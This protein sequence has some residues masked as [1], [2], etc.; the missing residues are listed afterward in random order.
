MVKFSKR[1]KWLIGL[2]FA[3]LVLTALMN[4]GFIAI[5]DYACIIE[6]IIPAQNLTFNQVIAERDIRSPFAPLV[7]LGVTKLGWYLGIQDP[8]WQFRFLSLLVGFFSYSAFSWVGIRLFKENNRK[9]EWFLFL[10]GFYF[11][12]PVFFSRILIESL[13][14]PFITLSCWFAQHY[15]ER[16]DRKS[17]GL[18]LLF[19]VLA[20]MFRFQAGICFVGIFFLVALKRN[21]PELLV[22]VL[23]AIMGFL[24]TGALDYLL[25][26]AFHGSLF[27]YVGYNLKYSSG[28][29]VT[30]FYTFLLIFL[31]L[32][33]P[34]S[35]I[36]RY[37]G[38]SWKQEFAGLIAPVLYIS[39]FLFAHSIVPHKEE[40]FVIPILQLFLIL[41]VPFLAFIAA[42]N[43]RSWRL[44]WF[45]GLNLILLPLACF[46]IAQNNVISLVR[47]LHTNPNIKNIV[48]VE[49][50]FV[51]YTK[52][53]LLKPP[54]L[55]KLSVEDVEQLRG[56][57]CD[58]LIAIRRDYEKQLNQFLKFHTKL[59]EFS[60]GPLEELVIK[61]NPK[62]NIRRGTIALYSDPKCV[63]R[64]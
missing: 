20:S 31:G 39:V 25:T 45:V 43:P 47:F 50:T 62:Q 52:A 17:L 57:D 16:T 46:N 55:I 56:L 18:S 14:M 40:R 38:L 44:K 21:F 32:S 64:F 1:S 42:D 49:E 60:P 51:L 53:F 33:L 11:L 4:I 29:G 22:F 41:L 24:I 48:G 10:S 28:F 23:M 3:L 2:G 34:P 27:T 6:K 9:I 13:S 5:D 61:F 54:K 63:S 58:V 26:G 15:W 19:L 37:C 12:S 7:L 8:A 59:V 36:G 30:P 35:L